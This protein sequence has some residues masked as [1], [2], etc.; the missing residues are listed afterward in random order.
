M[1][2]VALIYRT[3]IFV[4]PRASDRPIRGN[5]YLA[6]KPAH[7]LAMFRRTRRRTVSPKLVPISGRN[8]LRQSPSVSCPCV[9]QRQGHRLHIRGAD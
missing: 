7:E 5:G 3:L 9:D 4:L 2:R 8:V 1:P 6:H